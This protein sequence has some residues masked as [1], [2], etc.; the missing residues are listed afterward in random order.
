M[1]ATITPPAGVPA[2]QRVDPRDRLADYERALAF[3]L[4][5]P[6]TVVDRVV[7]AEN[8]DSDLS[9]LERLA[10]RAGAGKEVELLSFDGLD[11][12][13]E[14]GRAVGET[15]L[16]DTA[17]GRSRLL[18]ALAADEPFWKVT[19][20]LRFTNLD[21]L[22][23]TAPAGAELYIDFRRFP[24]RW[25][26]I[27]IFAC[28]PRA[29]RELFASREPLMRQDQLDR[30]GYSAPEERLFEELLPL[31][32]RARVAPRLR[33][34]PRVEG[35]SGHGQDYARPSRRIWSAV[36]GIVRRLCPPLWI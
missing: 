6:P 27:R 20:R 10:E 30:S 34:E 8:S 16:I 26:D 2:L 9:S 21:R 33:L 15:R 3:Y 24:R 25:V 29:F 19:G 23:E 22:I 11:Y 14:H 35:Y 1:T 31:R 4:G 28:T 7:F 13:V 12:P 5:L 17:L 36:R 18:G 32:E